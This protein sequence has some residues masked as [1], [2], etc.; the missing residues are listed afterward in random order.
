M[1]GEHEAM[2]NELDGKVAVITGAARGIGKA[3]ALE[4]AGMG[5]TTVLLARDK[6]ALNTVASEITSSGGQAVVFA[7]DLTDSRALDETTTAILNLHKHCDILV[8]NAGVGFKGEPLH[9][10]S[11]NDWE[12]IMKTNLRAPYL[13]LR[14]FAPNMIA[15]GGGHIINISSLAGKN[16]LPNGAI[17]A[18][19][20]WGLNGMMI[21]AA[22]EL[23]AHNVRV[24]IISPGSVATTF[25]GSADDPRATRKIQPVD[26]ARVVRM[27][28]TQDHQCF[29]S[30]VLV[31]PTS[32]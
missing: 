22:E 26:I 5:A 21:S 23:R 3:I 18:A 14:A 29:V 27:I 24:S 16:P 10:T 13:M 31:R 15:S 28:V 6:N 25:G 30:E 20:K 9:Q 32:K 17:Y 1:H 7:C 2:T 8:N 11:P 12:R 4:L 19:S